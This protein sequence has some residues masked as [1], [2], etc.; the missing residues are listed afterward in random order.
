MVPQGPVVLLQYNCNADKL[1][2][3]MAFNLLLFVNFLPWFSVLN[4][5]H[6]RHNSC[7]KSPGVSLLLCVI[8]T[9]FDVI[10]LKCHP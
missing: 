1:C 3:F 8:K 9:I 7:I 2:G 5:S 4:V 10:L 6:K